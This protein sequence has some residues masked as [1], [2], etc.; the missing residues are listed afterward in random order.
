MLQFSLYLFIFWKYRAEAALS[1]HS[2]KNFLEKK[3][4]Y[5]LNIRRRIW[6][7]NFLQRSHTLYI[8]LKLKKATN[9]N[10]LKK[11]I[12]KSERNGI[13]SCV[14]T[15]AGQKEVGMLLGN[16]SIAKATE[17]V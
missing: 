11:E 9:S 12:G 8:T 14:I 10:W 7:N 2:P 4:K 16:S 17:P 6:T 3:S 15:A 5:R 1:K 13:Q